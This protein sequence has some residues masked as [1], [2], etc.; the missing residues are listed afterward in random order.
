[1]RERISFD[2]PAEISHILHVRETANKVCL[3]MGF[4]PHD[5]GLIITAIWEA[6]LNAVTHGSP[7]GPNDRILVDILVSNNILHV[8]ITSNKPDFRLPDTPPAF[9]PTSRRGRG[10]PILYAF[11][12]KVWLTPEENRV[13]LHME[14]RLKPENGFN[15]K[16]DSQKKTC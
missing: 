14:K 11:M 15:L 1:M 5:T 16:E 10:I 12:D 8:D 7:N 9:D 4:S 3:E 2:F 6:A 13:T